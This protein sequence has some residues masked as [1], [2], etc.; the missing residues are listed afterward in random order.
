MNRESLQARV[1]HRINTL[2]DQGDV[3]HVTLGDHL[4]LS[5]SAVTRLLND[6]GGISLAHIEKLCA[7]FQITAAELMAEPDAL[8]QPLKPI[9]AAIVSYLRQMSEL[10]RRSLLTLLERPA[11][12]LAKG[13]RARLG[14][15]ML[16]VKEQ[17]LIDLFAR[18]KRDGVREGVLKTLRGAAQ[19]SDA[20]A[21]PHT[22]E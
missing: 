20:V 9:E 18:V 7:F 4:G 5:R 2:V 16:S 21:K 3:S 8:I 10:E 19:D 14:R 1:R 13:K 15:A 11:Y 12:Q 17:E 6:K 22:T